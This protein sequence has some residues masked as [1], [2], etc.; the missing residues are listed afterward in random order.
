M[1]YYALHF[2]LVF[3]ICAILPHHL[4]AQNPSV[5]NVIFEQNG[6]DIIV[7]YTLAGD[8]NKKYNITLSVSDDFGRTFQIKPFTVAGDVGRDIRVGTNKQI[9]WRLMRD[10]PVGLEGDSYV[11][12]VDAALQKGGLKWPYIIGAAVAGGAVYYLTSRKEAAEPTPTT[13][14]ITIQVP[15]D[16]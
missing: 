3:V 13:G 11:F 6:D 2:V 10:F 9:I 7:Q 8:A 1:R 16:F 15:V 14:S 12:A 5:R 4:K